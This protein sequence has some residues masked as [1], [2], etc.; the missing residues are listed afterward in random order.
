[1][2][3]ARSRSLTLIVATLTILLASCGNGESPDVSSLATAGPSETVTAPD[4]VPTENVRDDSYVGEIAVSD[5]TSD[6]TEIAIDRATLEDTRGWVVIHRD[7]SGAPGEV[8]GYVQLP[9]E[10]PAGERP[11]P[12]TVTLDAPLEPGDHPLWA[13]L[14]LDAE[15]VGTYGFP[16]EDV[17][18][19]SD[20]AVVMAPFTVTV[21]G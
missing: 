12:L 7:E 18:V 15:P 9:A 3:D 14:H 10:E 20:D 19:T 1:M 6:G 11:D 21:E 4:T 16:G 13:M 8:L 2:L 17:P 5:Q